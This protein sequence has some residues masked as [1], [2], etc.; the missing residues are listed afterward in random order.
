MRYRKNT[1]WQYARQWRTADRK[2]ARSRQN[3]RGSAEIVNFGRTGLSGNVHAK[4]V[5]LA[6]CL[7]HTVHAVMD[8]LPHVVR[9]IQCIYNLRLVLLH[10][11]AA[12]SCHAVQKGQVIYGSGSLQA[13]TYNVPAGLVV[14]R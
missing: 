14:Y 6:V 9:N 10:Q 13:L 1:R 2:P 3:F 5:E 8:I 12:G 7:Y 11:V 4:T